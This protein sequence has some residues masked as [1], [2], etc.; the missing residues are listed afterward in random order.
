M[1][2]DIFPEPEMFRPE[3]FLNPDGKSLRKIEE[4]VP[5]S[6]GKRSCMGESLAKME[7]FMIFA[8]LIKRF[9]F[10]VKP[11]VPLPSLETDISFVYSPKPYEVLIQPA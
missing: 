5:F 3:R 1:E 8:T 10:S 4:F 2:P 6:L 9:K 7:L 11:G